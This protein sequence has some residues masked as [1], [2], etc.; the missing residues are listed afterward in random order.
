M[1]SFERVPFSK[2]Y[3]HV[4]ELYHGAFSDLNYNALTNNCQHFV[5]ELARPFDNIG[6]VE[7]PGISVNVIP[8]V[9]IISNPFIATDLDAYKDETAIDKG[10]ITAGMES[11]EV[12]SS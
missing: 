7:L 11:Y 10:S 9:Q 5:R 3:E 8:C 4:K 2:I 1:K 6:L 12:Y